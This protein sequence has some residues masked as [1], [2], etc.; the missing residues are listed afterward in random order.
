[1]TAMFNL[2]FFNLNTNDGLQLLFDVA[3]KSLLVLTLAQ[4]MVALLKKYS[5]ATR[6]LIL[7]VSIAAVL[8]IP[9]LA[10]SLPAIRFPVL[11]TLISPTVADV[12]I[13]NQNK[14]SMEPT[15]SSPAEINKPVTDR[16]ETRFTAQ[17]P[18]ASS[19][20]KQTELY[21]VDELSLPPVMALPDVASH[22]ETE[23]RQS[24]NEFNWG[25]LILAIWLGGFLMVSCRF[26]FGL[27][28]V[29]FIALKATPVTDISWVTLTHSLSNRLSLNKGVKILKTERVSL[30]M[31][32]GAF[33]SVIL[34]PEAADDWSLKGRSIVLLHELAHVKRRDCLTQ[35]L[36]QM[37]CAIY[38]F[39][40]QVWKLAARLRVERELACDDEVL[41][42]GTRPSDYAGYLV[43]IA[44][45]FKAN[46]CVSPFAVGMACSE[47]ENRVRTILNT[48]IKRQTNSRQRV[49]FTT[50]IATLLI[51][52]LAIIQP[53]SK[54]EAHIAEVNSANAD[55]EIAIVENP[56]EV[57]EVAGADN[58]PAILRSLDDIKASLQTQN[59]AQVS[60]KSE[61]QPNPVIAVN[62]TNEANPGEVTTGEGQGRGQG[63]GT[64]IGAGS[65]A[66]TGTGAGAGYGVGGGAG[67]G[68]G[69]NS[70]SK[71]KSTKPLTPNEFIRLKMADVTPEYI[72][73]LKKM[74]FD[75]LSVH[76]IAELKIHNIDEAY[77]RQVQNWGF[78]KPTVR[79]L[80]QLKV[81]GVT[82]DYISSI[83]KAGF[84]QL[85][86]RQLTSLKTFNV[87][88][89]YIDA[90]RKL[91]FGKLTLNQVISLRSQNI[92][93]E[94]IRQAESWTGEKLTLNQLV[95]IKVHNLTPAFANEVK[96][97]GF[98]NVSFEKL[99]QIKIH[100]ITAD[101]VKE[102]R[103][104]G[105]DNLTLEQVLRLKI[106]NVTPDYVRKIRAAGF[107]NV[108]LNQLLEM[109]MHGL[110]EILLRNSK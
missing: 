103:G 95:Q 90:L 52:P 7:S 69:Q 60:S 94:F 92:N 23:K 51:I 5:A 108:S 83:K 44:R 66:G 45:S 86:V 68:S 58:Q 26:A 40:P 56:Y 31:T 105:F 88:P 36:A 16:N 48:N 41:Q 102:M 110:D 10:L 11:P 33:R 64:G 42:I 63:S 85:T 79:D 47:L 50:L 109:K 81:S 89:Q 28:N 12:H 20:A 21:R 1:M 35:T 37:A 65:G 99:L 43:E 27:F 87:T 73:S 2:V 74:G 24:A 34:L 91:G 98:D 57:N 14:M 30:P 107:K 59:A 61:N 25:G 84:E 67:I 70:E 80:I 6:H 19:R 93:E 53:R 8:L 32:W 55:N 17:E 96:A 72:E 62:F 101:F 18:M 39:N 15:N 76:Q 3:M 104:L 82:G 38:W 9:V 49:A 77:V 106:H 22:L 29:W 78:D 75:N 100:G 13:E 4:V 54:V 46:V 97:M 71:N